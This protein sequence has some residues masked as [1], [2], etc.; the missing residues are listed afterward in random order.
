MG[1]VGCVFSK[2]GCAAISLAMPKLK[3]YHWKL[4]Y[5]NLSSAALVA[6][7]LNLGILSE[8]I[9]DIVPD[10]SHFGDSIRPIIL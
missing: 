2:H 5:F 3:L 9:L 8:F 10:P 4:S 6:Y 7:F 1:V